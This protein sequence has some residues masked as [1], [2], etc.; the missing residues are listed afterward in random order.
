MSQTD[1]ADDADDVL[2][3]F[4]YS[5]HLVRIIGRCQIRSE[6]RH[7]SYADYSPPLASF[8]NI[9]LNLDANLA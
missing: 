3:R 5:P 7:F 8:T 2:H 4:S 9:K 6:L 1:D